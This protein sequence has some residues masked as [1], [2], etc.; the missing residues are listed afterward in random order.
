MTVEIITAG[1]SLDAAAEIERECFPDPWSKDEMA[2]AL[3][4][5]A[6][7]CFGGYLDGKLVSYVMISIASDECE[8]LNVA[9]KPAYRRRGIGESLLS[10]AL[11]HAKKKGAETVWLEVRKSNAPAKALYE[12]LGF[13]K[14]GTRKNYYR[15]PVEDAIIM[16]SRL[17]FCRG[18]N[19]ADPCN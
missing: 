5:P 17:S 6:F 3:R 16:M 1:V 14:A 18:D 15:K 19:D 10:K 11:Y 2:A 12:K 9:V 13:S 4:N 8:I 7:S